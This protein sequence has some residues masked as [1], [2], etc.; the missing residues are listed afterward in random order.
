MNVSVN[1]N[2]GGDVSGIKHLQRASAVRIRGALAL[3]TL[4]RPHSAQVERQADELELGLRL[5]QTPH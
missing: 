3:I 5:L 1:G 4:H 2:A